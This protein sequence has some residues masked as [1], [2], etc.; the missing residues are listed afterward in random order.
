MAHGYHTRWIW[1]E[2]DYLEQEFQ[3]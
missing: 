1:D 2:Q 3:I